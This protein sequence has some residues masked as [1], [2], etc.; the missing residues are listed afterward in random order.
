MINKPTMSKHWLLALWEFAYKTFVTIS[1][2]N[3]YSLQDV[4]NIDNI[5]ILHNDKNSLTNK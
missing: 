2:T 3:V 4:N 5:S 1:P